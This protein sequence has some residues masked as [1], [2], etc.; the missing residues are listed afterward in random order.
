MMTEEDRLMLEMADTVARGDE[1]DIV[2]GADAD[3]HPTDFDM[4]GDEE[5]MLGMVD[6]LLDG[7]NRKAED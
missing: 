4:L 7:P 2:M 6:L 5:R 1:V 3:V